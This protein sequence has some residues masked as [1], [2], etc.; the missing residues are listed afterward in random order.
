MEFKLSLVMEHAMYCIIILHDYCY[1]RLSVFLLWILYIYIIFRI[2]HV[3]YYYIIWIINWKF[4]FNMK[5]TNIRGILSST[6]INNFIGYLRA[7]FCRNQNL[8]TAN[9]DSTKRVFHSLHRT[10]I[11]TKWVSCEQLF[12]EE[13]KNNIWSTEEE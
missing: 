10:C 2:N 5:N 13:K 6:T 12:R 3:Y 11:D 7:I 8:A 1:V 9:D 4:N